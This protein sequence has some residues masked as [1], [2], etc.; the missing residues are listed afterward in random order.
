MQVARI[1]FAALLM[2]M[3]ANAA[4][5]ACYAQQ[6]YDLVAL[7][8]ATMADQRVGAVRGAEVASASGEIIG[9]VAEVMLHRGD[10]SVHAVLDVSEWAQR[11]ATRFAVPAEELQLL[12]S[13]Q[14]LYPAEVERGLLRRAAIAFDEEQYVRLADPEASL[15]VYMSHQDSTD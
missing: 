15:A 11:R 9:R 10:Y 5:G 6:R 7:P 2:F 3:T 8:G 13:D 1:L 12:A 14:L 4:A